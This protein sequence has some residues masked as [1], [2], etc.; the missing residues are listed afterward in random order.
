MKTA[1]WRQSTAFLRRELTKLAIRM[2]PG[3][4][5]VR[6]LLRRACRPASLK[7]TAQHIEVRRD[8]RV[9]RIAA[10]H[11]PYA[12]DMASLFDSYFSQVVPEK[13]GPDLVVDY[14]GP[15]LQ[16]YPNGVQFEI[17][18]MPEEAETIESYFYW[19]KPS[20]GDTIFDIGA[21][22]GVSTYHF[23]KTVPNGKVI[24]FEPDSISY[25]LLVR[26][27]ERH[28]LTNVIAV[29][30]ALGASSGALTFASEGTM[31]SQLTHIS[32]RVTVGNV[33][34]VKVMAFEEIC[35][36]Y[37]LPDFVKVD[38]EG[39]EIEMVAA[40]QSFLRLHRI[41][42][43]LDTAH[44]IEGAMAGG[45]LTAHTIENLFQECGYET[46]S[47]PEFGCM[48]TWARPAR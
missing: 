26:N 39:A 12:L 25:D 29:N 33:R 46:R 2:G 8:H 28:G 15:R 17:A 1:A 30:A 5:L 4:P 45:E 37:G 24:A 18:S 23:A 19:Y 44:W 48:T 21:Y 36:T 13:I 38:I 47:S 41:L 27:I 34:T 3:S 43:A 31:G 35:Q 14:S 22:C 10:K 7:F 16:T 40:A 42:F 6:I 32:S 9:I 20:P 11:F